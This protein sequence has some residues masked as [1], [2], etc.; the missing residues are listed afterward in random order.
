MATMATT[1]GLNPNS[2]QIN[3]NFSSSTIKL[4]SRTISRFNCK[5][6]ANETHR[7][8]VVV[9]GAG[10]IGLSIAR[11]LL[12]RS[13]L[14]V[15]VVD[16]KFPCSGA[17][18]AG[19]GYLWMAHKT[20]GTAVWDLALRSQNLWQLLAE[21]L[22]DQG[23]DPLEELGW[24]KTGSLLIGRTEVELDQLKKLVHRLSAA[25]IRADYLS[26]ND[27]AAREPKLEVGRQSG[28]AFLPDDCQLD[29]YRTVAY[30]EKSNRVF[31]SRGRY[32]EFYDDPAVCLLRT[33]GKGKVEG[34]KTKRNTLYSEK[35]IIFA[36]GCWTGSVMNE[37]LKDSDIL[38]HVPVQ[39]RK[40]HLLVLENFNPLGLSHGLMEVGYVDHRHSISLP[41]KVDNEALSISMVASS[42]ASGNL[43]LGSSRQFAGFN[44]D[45]NSS[46]V[47]CIW[48]RAQQ[49]FP[50]LKEF[51]LENLS[52]LLN[53][54]IGLR[55]FMPDGKP[56][57]GPVPGMPNL[58]LATG[59]EGSG[60]SMALGTA[61][62]VTDMILDNPPKVDSTPFAVQG[63]CC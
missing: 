44:T 20:P 57:I 4:K 11:D 8:D 14:S 21:T 22:H 7:F 12:L 28:A 24:K 36:A 59:H 3:S 15:A 55:P 23:I 52:E 60:L 35:A 49:F 53:V 17:T 47:A 29:A 1:I 27:L 63:R 13:N 45:L 54:R 38:V 31:G 5:L 58:F 32:A 34:I 25:G 19:Q 46:V 9:V 26:S 56:V 51:S 50:I 39:P 6:S 41:G 33:K 16:A 61:E 2:N 37:L 48:E 40:G 10:I 30:I 62:L 42:D 43:L 18:G